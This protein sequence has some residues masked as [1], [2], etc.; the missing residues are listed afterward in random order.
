MQLSYDYAK[1]R[2]L[3]CLRA[4]YESH[5]RKAKSDD[6]ERFQEWVKYTMPKRIK[7]GA[8]AAVQDE[9]RA[10][11]SR[12]FPQSLSGFTKWRQSSRISIF[13]IWIG[14]SGLRRS[15]W[16]AG[17]QHYRNLQFFWPGDRIIVATTMHLYETNRYVYP[18]Q[19]LKMKLI[20]TNKICMPTFQLLPQ[21][22]E[23]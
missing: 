2:A 23:V 11:A 20:L 19:I 14:R 10:P 13:R 12:V 9:G 6:N 22:T 3:M 17:L 7:E 1:D 8:V 5:L 21:N 15:V 4:N 16:V 18:C